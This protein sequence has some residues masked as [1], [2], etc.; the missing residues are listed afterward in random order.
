MRV[1][2]FSFIEGIA[3]DY[4]PETASQIALKKYSKEVSSIYAYIYAIYMQSSIHFSR[5]LLLI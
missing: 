5:R 3:E 4:S 2:S 1:L